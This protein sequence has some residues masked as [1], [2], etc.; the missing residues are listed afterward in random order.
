MFTNIIVGV[1]GSQGGRDALALA[2]QLAAPAAAITLAHMYGDGRLFGKAAGLYLLEARR[3]SLALLDRERER[4][5]AGLEV[6][7][8]SAASPRLGRGLRLLAERR[9]ADLLAIGAC[10]RGKLGQILLGDHTAAA[11]N[12]APCA[13]AIA[14]RGYTAPERL[15]RIGVAYD[16]S[17]EA[18][19][20]LEVARTLASLHHARVSA[21]SA[22]SLQ[23]VP[24]GESIGSHLDEVAE[25]LYTEQQRLWNELMDIDTNVTFGR[26]AKAMANLS[27]SVDLLVVGSRSR[28]RLQR[29]LDGSTSNHLARHARCPVLVLPRTALGNCPAASEQDPAAAGRC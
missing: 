26:P 22:I 8:V 25:R 9:H 7:S 27:E 15:A 2:Q 18:S 6:S 11:L 24:Y 10:H 21:V 4:P 28:N 17:P 14:P 5:A 13:V 12:G 23:E 19:R 20:A 29:L 16:G 1:D 3:Q